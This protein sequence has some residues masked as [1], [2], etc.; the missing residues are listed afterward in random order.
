MIGR[1][2]LAAAL[3][4]GP[5]AVPLVGEAQPVPRIGRVG[6]L[7]NGE[8]SGSPS[9]KAFQQELK[10]RGWVEHRNLVF[11]SRVSHAALDR[12]PALAKDLV[13]RKVE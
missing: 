8:I 3:T 2:V 10:D 7:S 6:T 13:G 9:F 1:A 11:E 5:L 4:F 12:F